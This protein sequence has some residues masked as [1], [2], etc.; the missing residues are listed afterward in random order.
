MSFKNI[1]HLKG[2]AHLV[3]AI[4]RLNNRKSS[5]KIFRENKMSNPT[6]FI[7]LNESPATEYSFVLAPMVLH[8]H[9]KYSRLFFNAKM[10][11][12]C[13]MVGR[14]TDV[15]ATLGKM[16]SFEVEFIPPNT[17]QMLKEN[18]GSMLSFR[19][20]HGHIYPKNLD[21]TQH[22]LKIE[23]V[24]NK[25]R[26]VDIPR[27]LY[28]YGQA[29]NFSLMGQDDSYV[30]A[31]KTTSAYTAAKFMGFDEC[32]LDDNDNILT[33]AHGKQL[34]GWV[35]AIWLAWI[36][37]INQQ[38][39]LMSMVLTE[40]EDNDEDDPDEFVEFIWDKYRGYLFDKPLAETLFKKAGPY[41]FNVLHGG[42]SFNEIEMCK[43]IDKATDM[44]LQL[45]MHEEDVSEAQDELKRLQEQGLS[46]NH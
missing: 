31:I 4:C 32:K 5:N 36:L 11:E 15:Q 24:D 33:Y 2:T 29:I 45:M 1:Q 17:I 27:V 26:Y 7:G 19:H 3:L 16:F 43:Q 9:P 44:L 13:P 22:I 38:S 39:L 41:D 12:E 8:D 37:G 34:S 21:N 42:N 23:A 25:L 14:I 35:N 20:Y 40:I 28:E 30:E 18:Q 6:W 10:P 46:V